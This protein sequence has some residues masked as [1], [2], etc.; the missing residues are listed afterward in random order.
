[1]A[2]K[3]VITPDAEADLDGFLEY[4]IIEKDSVTAALNVLNDFEETKTKL[5][6][7]AGNL[8]TCDNPRLKELGYRRIN[9]RTHNYFLLYRI[10]ENTVTIDNIFHSSQDYENK[11]I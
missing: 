7:V 10:E 5:S 9:F 11:M 6:E 2:Y 8:K 3:V 1:M 4:L